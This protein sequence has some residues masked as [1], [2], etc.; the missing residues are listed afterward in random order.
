MTSVV[1]QV[2]RVRWDGTDPCGMTSGVWTVGHVQI[3]A[4]LPAWHYV[5]LATTVLLNTLI[6]FTIMPIQHQL[7]APYYFVVALYFPITANILLQG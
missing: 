3:P 4:E 6:K 5:F 7:N 1:W 2:G